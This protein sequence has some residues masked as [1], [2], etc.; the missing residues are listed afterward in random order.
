MSMSEEEDEKIQQI[1]ENQM[2]TFS[3]EMAREVDT[4]LERKVRR[5]L[6]ALAWVLRD[7]YRGNL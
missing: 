2:Q 7:Y 4:A 1:I 6:R 3:A 5:R